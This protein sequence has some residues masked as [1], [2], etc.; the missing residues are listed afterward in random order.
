M[1]S[2][3][4]FFSL[5]F[6]SIKVSACQCPTTALSLDECAKYEIIFKGKIISVSPCNN[7]FG[8]AVFEISE[9]YKGAITKKFKI[10]FECEAECAQPILVGEEWIIYSRFKQVNNGLLDWCSRS[11]KFFAIEKQDLYTVNFGNTYD[12]EAKFLGTKL[13]MHRPL[14][15]VVQTTQNR[16]IRPSLTQTITI[17]ICSLLAMIGFYWFLRKN[18]HKF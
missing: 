2:L 17:L 6:L 12:E 16:N 18:F 14:T 5:I 7:K 13:G 11:R 4:I 8:E 9:L 15:E 10:L 1:R 3:F